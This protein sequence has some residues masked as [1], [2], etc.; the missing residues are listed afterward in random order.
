MNRKTT[1]EDFATVV[2]LLTGKENQ[3]R[4]RKQIKGSCRRVGYIGLTACVQNPIYIY[5]Y[6][7]ILG[8][9]QELGLRE[10]RFFLKIF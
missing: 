4:T 1:V 6:I 7:Y 3:L 10:I 5:I 2:P 8:G 9:V